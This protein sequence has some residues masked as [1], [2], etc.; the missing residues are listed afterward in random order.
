LPIAGLSGATAASGAAQASNDEFDACCG[1]HSTAADL[2][3][4]TRSRRPSVR[5]PAARSLELL[6]DL[7]NSEVSLRNKG[8]VVIC[9]YKD[10]AAR[11]VFAARPHCSQCR[12][13]Q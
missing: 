2:V 10:R 4:T 8:N 11:M 9:T 6:M 12:Q 13:L 3:P 5:V 7:M 1:L